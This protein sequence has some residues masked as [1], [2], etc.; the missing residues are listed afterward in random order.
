MSSK[1][2]AVMEREFKKK[3]SLLNMYKRKNLQTSS[4]VFEENVEM[5][6]YAEELPFK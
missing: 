4:S 1:Q 3:T 6:E 2:Y 5:N